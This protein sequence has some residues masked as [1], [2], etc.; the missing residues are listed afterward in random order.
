MISEDLACQEVV[1]LV[2]EYLEGTLSPEVVDAFEQHLTICEGCAA[3]LEQMR[4]A[5]RLA[6]KLHEDDVPAPVMNRLLDAFRDWRRA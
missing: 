4:E 2:T 3:Y 1:E 5:V 6:G